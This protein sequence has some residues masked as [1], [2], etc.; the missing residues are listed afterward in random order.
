MAAAGVSRDFDALATSMRAIAERTLRI[1]P[2]IRL[3]FVTNLRPEATAISDLGP[4]GVDNVAQHYW[5]RAADE[6][7]RSLQELGLTVESYF[8]E[9]DLVR[10]LVDPAPQ[11]DT[12]PRVVYSTAEGG[13]G[14]GRRA[15]IPSLC[16]L[17]G[18]PILNCGAHASSMVRHKFHA[19][20]VLRRVGVRVPDTW[21]FA[22]G[23]WT[24][25]LAPAPGARVIVKP[26]YES[27]GI[28]VGD[29]SVQIVDSG[30]HAFMA[31]KSRQF[32]QPAIAQE[33]VSGREVGVPVARLGATWALP[34]ITQLRG[35]GSDFGDRP[36]TFRDEHVARDLAHAAFDGPDEQVGAMLRAA[37]LSFD[38]LDMR[39]VGRID[40]RVDADGRAWAFDTNGE[41]PPVPHTCW[42]AAME[43]LGFTFSELL[44]VWVGI[45]LSDHGL[46]SQ[47]SDQNDSSTHGI[48]RP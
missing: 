13:S 36:K 47:E 4:D 3:L 48:N 40:F 5:R 28:G 16:N 20:S 37:A 15:L 11:G 45:C 23:R 25:A 2:G 22:D 12:R 43:R 24:G 8:S 7:I 31:N 46:L 10:A 32:G 21:Q 18:I 38:A 6:I 39:G 34:A 42:S 44:A 26:V 14:S 29:D 27:M 19:F 1:A 9:L 35:D 17:M 33:F 41:P 30:F